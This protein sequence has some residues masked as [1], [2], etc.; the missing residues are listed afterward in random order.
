MVSS[1]DFE[2]ECKKNRGLQANCTIGVPCLGKTTAGTY[3]SETFK[4]KTMKIKAHNFTRAT[5]FLLLPK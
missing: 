3:L 2:T 5:T 1:S 4:E